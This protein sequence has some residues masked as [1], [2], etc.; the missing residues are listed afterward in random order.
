MAK[1]AAKDT[2]GMRL[3]AEDLRIVDVRLKAV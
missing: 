3:A 2:S 1:R